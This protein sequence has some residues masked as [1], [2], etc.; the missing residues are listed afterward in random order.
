MMKTVKET[1]HWLDARLPIINTFERHLSKHPVPSWVNFWYLFGALA[2]AVLIL[3]IITG[4]WMLMFYENG[5]NLAFSSIQYIMRDVEFGW[6]LRYFHSTGASFLF[7]VVYLH[8][9]RGLLYGSYR[10]P[11]ELVWLLGM[12]TFLVLMGEGFFG[13]VLPFGQ[14]S[15]WGAQVIVSLFGA[16]PLIGD[17]LVEWFRGDYVISGATLGRF[18]ALHA[19]V[20]PLAMVAL[21]FMH[22]VALH[23]VGVGNQDGVDLESRR[24]KDGVPIGSIPFFPYKVLQAMFATIVMMILFCIVA[25]YMPKF[26]GLFLEAPN[27]EKASWLKTPEHIVPVWYFMPFYAM[28]RA[29]T[30]PLLGLDA[31]FWGLVVMMSAVIIP[32]VLPWL[33]RSPVASMRYKGYFSRVS[34]AVMIV[35]FLV[36]GYLGAVPPSEGREIVAQICTLGYFSY[37]LLMPIYTRLEQTKPVLDPRDAKLP[38][39]EAKR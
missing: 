22:L 27:F 36:L 13:Y 3:Q 12:V 30:F 21:V 31:K 33:D 5:E 23:E 37:F 38:L 39:A 17:S 8:L 20:L 11:R 16:V 18:L 25:F 6:L 4:V 2:M 14:M 19:V 9:F 26:F 10:R 24:D 15:Y 34:L 1:L 7:I 32:F 28:L 29:C 35:C